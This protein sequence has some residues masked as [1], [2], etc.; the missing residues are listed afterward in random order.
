MVPNDDALYGY[1]HTSTALHATKQG[2]TPDLRDVVLVRTAVQR[3]WD[4]YTPFN[5]RSHIK[6]ANLDVSRGRGCVWCRWSAVC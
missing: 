4:V 1:K 5:L 2:V 3:N 6:G